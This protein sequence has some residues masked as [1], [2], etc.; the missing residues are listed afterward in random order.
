MGDALLSESEVLESESQLL[1]SE[2]S[3][4]GTGLSLCPLAAGRTLL[5]FDRSLA[6]TA[7]SGPCALLLVD[8]TMGHEEVD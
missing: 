2:S 6:L 4:L 1:E 5:L 7:R 3:T 8:E